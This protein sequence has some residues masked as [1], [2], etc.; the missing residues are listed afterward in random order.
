MERKH[1]TTLLALMLLALV[2][3]VLTGCSSTLY[4]VQ[5]P[6]GVLYCV[7][8]KGQQLHAPAK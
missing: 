6:Q 4:K 5:T 1:L 3:L 7:G 2:V 8:D